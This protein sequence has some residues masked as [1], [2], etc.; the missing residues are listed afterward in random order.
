MT[1]YP[2]QA[3]SFTGLSQLG[4][5]CNDGN[6][7][8]PNGIKSHFYAF[9]VHA[10]LCTQTLLADMALVDIFYPV[11]RL[12]INS[13]K[14]NLRSC[15]NFHTP[16]GVSGFQDQEAALPS[17]DGVFYFALIRASVQKQS[18]IKKQLLGNKEGSRLSVA[19][20]CTSLAIIML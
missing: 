7:F 2:E 3:N 4:K 20:I 1:F 16:S 10:I 12:C 8:C 18:S 17:I 14:I 6:T 11:T 13:E 9:N 5:T 19:L 15:N